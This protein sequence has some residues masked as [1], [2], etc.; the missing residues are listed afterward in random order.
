MILGR[1]SLSCLLL[2]MVFPALAAAD[3]RQSGQQPTPRPP[4]DSPQQA[5][6]LAQPPAA[7]PQETPPKVLLKEGTEVPLKLA[8]KLDAKH[9]VQ[10]E[11]VEFV[12]ADDLKV[13]EALVA[14]KGARVL[15]TVTVGKETEKRG[16]ARALA[17]RVDFFRVGDARVKLRG[18]KPAEGKR[19][20]EA[21]VAGTIL[22]GLSGLL[23]TSGKHY[24]LPDGT[25]VSAYVAEDIG[26]PPIR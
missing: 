9:A 18:D 6:K 5:Q 22:L 25:P 7:P 2:G 15:G 17:V 4:Q 23:M 24:V 12:L 10:G 19:N 20:K 14:R 13:G 21:M 1:S 26:L 16:D 8:Q 11:P 3:F